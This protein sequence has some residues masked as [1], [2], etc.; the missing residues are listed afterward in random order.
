MRA[1]EILESPAADAKARRH[2]LQGEERRRHGRLPALN[3]KLG[4]RLDDDF[5]RVRRM[6]LFFAI[7]ASKGRLVGKRYPAGARVASE[8]GK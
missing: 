7:N 3:P 2:L 8:S 5:V 4:R 1:Q 6:R